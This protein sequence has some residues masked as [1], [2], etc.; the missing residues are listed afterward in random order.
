MADFKSVD[1]LMKA[2]QQKVEK[3]IQEKVP[4]VVAKEMQMQ[5]GKEVYGVYTP[6]MYKREYF[7]GG[8]IDPDNIESTNI[9]GGVS[10]RNVREDEGRDVAATVETGIGYNYPYEGMGPRP[11]TE[12]TRD[13]LE[14]SR[15]HVLATKRGLKDMGINVE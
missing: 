14:N 1:A 15:A 10:I 13:E 12:A 9:P 6:K 8:L 4:E 11:F 7:H 3:A 5:I 2:L